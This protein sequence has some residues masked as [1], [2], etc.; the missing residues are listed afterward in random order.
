MNSQTTLNLL[1]ATIGDLKHLLDTR[2]ITSVELVALYLHRIGRYD[3]RGPCLNS[4]TVINPDVFAEA[5]ASD[6]YRASGKPP[7]P[8]EGIPFT[9][10]DSYKVKGMTV[11]AASPA[12]A[13]LE[14]TCDAA[15]VELL[16]KAGAVVLG[17][18]N[19]PP[20]ADGG[21]QRGLYG[22][23]ESPYNQKYMPTAYASGSSYGCGVS[24]AAGLAAFGFAGE[25]VTS[26]R[27]PASNNALVGYAPSRSVIPPRGLWPLYPTCD[28]VVPHTRTMDDL[29]QVLNVVVADDD[30]AGDADFW[31]SQPYVPI[32]KVSDIR[33]SD[34]LTLANP[35]ALR[36]KRLAVPRCFI[37]VE[38]AKPE[39][40]CSVGVRALWDRA[41]ADIEKLGATV[42]ETDF[43]LFENYTRQDFP[44]Q[45]MNVPNLPEDWPAIE[46]CEMIAL[47][48]NSFLRGNGDKDIPSF[49]SGVELDKIHPH[50]APMDDPSQHTESQ[51]QVR[52]EDMVAA[53]KSWGD[54]SLA[55]LPG[56]REALQA[57]EA[58][59]KKY[60]ED[61]M[62][63]NNYDAVV[64]PTNGDVA[65]A[66]SDE[67]Y[68]SMMSAL[69]D[70]VKYAN[71]G[72]SLK[73]LGVPCITVPMGNLAEEK[74]PVGLSFCGRAYD[75]SN[76]LS[77]AFAY[78]RATNR[79][80]IP[81]LAPS[82]PSDEISITIPSPASPAIATPTL[83]IAS[84]TSVSE[85]SADSDVR[86]VKVTGSCGL[87]DSNDS[88]IG[89]DVFA[90]G[91]PTSPVSWTGNNWVWTGR[92][93]RP[94]RDDK[95]PALAKV[96]RDQFL[97]VLVAKSD[98]GRSAGSLILLD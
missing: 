86:V 8:L 98:N 71:G 26:G 65:L 11:A 66:D 41:R 12:F 21:C 69:R 74:M 22:R 14:A 53:V 85:D 33:P 38:G 17:K 20:M 94:K 36:N 45:S 63:E 55:D 92:L 58:M 80:E 25:A 28:Q 61:W 54:K 73:H 68:E 62:A 23:S 56:C 43:P 13:K 82:L 35:D 1:D 32:P 44:G 78:E 46:R 4:I 70:G 91:E 84:I 34:Y 40:A 27:S 87:T 90:N 24:T 10:K 9:V 6:D 52:Y 60:L 37:G 39:N 31:R 29:F 75:D 97:L 67:N 49:T 42:I 7:R 51:N 16:R 83:G 88:S 18:T 89:L 96:P 59:R 95:Y 5:Q 48:W 50:I 72:R 47:S 19:M 79:R 30:A 64:F 3:C 15:I 2:A 81:P 57:L 93:T 76:L 77:Y